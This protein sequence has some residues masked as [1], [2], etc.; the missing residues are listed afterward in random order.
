MQVPLLGDLFFFPALMQNAH[1]AADCSVAPL[2]KPGLAGSIEP[3]L[4]DPSFQRH[5]PYPNRE[6][7]KGR[8]LS[9]PAVPSQPLHAFSHQ[10]RRTRENEPREG[11]EG[12]RELELEGNIFILKE[13]KKQKNEGFTFLFNFSVGFWFFLISK[14]LQLSDFESH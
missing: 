4:C 1:R 6:Y 9:H 10:Q 12:I 14:F 3:Y 7:S 8:T 5:C 2:R 13:N 11:R